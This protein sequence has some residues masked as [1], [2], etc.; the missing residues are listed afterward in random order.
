[1]AEGHAGIDGDKSVGVGHDDRKEA[2]RAG[3]V[4][5]DPPQV[6]LEELFDQDLFG[7]VQVDEAA[8]AADEKADSVREDYPA[9]LVATDIE[10]QPITD[11]QRERRQPGVQRADQG[12]CRF[13][14]SKHLKLGRP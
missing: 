8:E 7:P 14:C 5:F 12:Q 10:R 2:D 3:R 1:M 9:G 4:S 11:K 13:P 6:G